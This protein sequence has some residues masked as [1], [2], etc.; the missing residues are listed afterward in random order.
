MSASPTRPED[1]KLVQLLEQLILEQRH[2]F[3]TLQNNAAGLDVP[4]SAEG[5]WACKQ[6]I[7][8]ASEWP[9]PRDFSEEPIGVD[10]LNNLWPEGLSLAPRDLA[11]P[12]G[13]TCR[14]EGYE[15]Q[16]QPLGDLTQKTNL[17]VVHWV[18]ERWRQDPYSGIEA[19]P[20]AKNGDIEVGPAI[21][22]INLASV[23][24]TFD[25]TVVDG[26]VLS[27]GFHEPHSVNIPHMQL[28]RG[29]N[30]PQSAQRVNSIEW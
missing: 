14:C 30:D 7:W 20:R 9:L 18:L 5:L 26:R 11:A 12:P 17:D 4:A 21:D 22:R 3:H 16:C 15:H 8:S 2:T 10:F 27:I 23:P 28:R 6:N 1:T 25:R 29:L 24:T 19:E 13:E